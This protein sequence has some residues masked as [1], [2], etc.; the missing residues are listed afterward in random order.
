M[1]RKKKLEEKVKSG[2]LRT[3]N[4]K[5]RYFAEKVAVNKQAHKTFD[6]LRI[7]MGKQIVMPKDMQMEARTVHRG[8]AVTI[9]GIDYYSQELWP[10]IDKQVYFYTRD[11]FQDF[12]RLYI[13]KNNKHYF[14]CR[15]ETR[16]GTKALVFKNSQSSEIAP[17]K[18]QF[19]VNHITPLNVSIPCLS[20]GGE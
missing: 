5:R 7:K 19:Q 14:L 17:H 18:C 16:E 4:K 12:I 20:V 13:R 10:H 15:A 6:E 1:N 11:G 9:N 2:G 8:P 3:V